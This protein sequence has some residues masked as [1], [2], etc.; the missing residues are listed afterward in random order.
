MWEIKERKLLW[1][2]SLPRDSI[3]NDMIVVFA[4]DGKHFFSGSWDGLI[5]AWDA[6]SGARLGT[7]LRIGGGGV[8]SLAIS[9]D[10]SRLIAVSDK[11]IIQ[12]WAVESFLRRSTLTSCRSEVTGSRGAVKEISPI[13]DR[14]RPEPN[15]NWIKTVE[16]NPL[17]WVPEEHRGILCDISLLRLFP[18]KEEVTITISWDELHHGTDW[19]KVRRVPTKRAGISSSNA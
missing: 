4:N 1:K 10:D 12:V 11:G 6:A 18:N 8:R 3:K 13:R 9:P 14:K 15:D 2:S 16:G 5:Y 19:T 17:L 7:P